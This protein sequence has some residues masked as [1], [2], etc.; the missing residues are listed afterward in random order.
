ML[1]RAFDLILVIFAM[2]LWLP[3]I[4]LIALASWERLGS[5]LFFR[6]KPLGLNGKILE[7]IKFRTMR[8][9]RGSDGRPLPAFNSSKVRWMGANAGG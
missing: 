9:A 3:L 8:E 5:P 6:Q 2:P 4:A 1:K 7:L